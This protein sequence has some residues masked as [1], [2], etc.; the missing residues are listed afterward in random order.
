MLDADGGTPVIFYRKDR[1]IYM[2]GGEHLEE[3]RLNPNSPTRRVFAAR[4]NAVMFM[5]FTKGHRLSLYRNR[6]GAAGRN[7][8]HGMSG[9]A[10]ARSRTACQIMQ[11]FQEASCGS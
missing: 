10:M 11:D 1:I 2:R 7:A 9:A 3:R 5:D 6:F 4:C 8:D